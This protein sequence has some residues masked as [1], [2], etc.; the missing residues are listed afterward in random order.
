[1]C[2]TALIIAAAAVAASAAS[3]G[4]SIQSSNAQAANAQYE[5]KVEQQRI[6][7]Q[8]QAASLQ[9]SQQQQ[10]RGREFQRARSSALAS[11]GASG[12]QEN[13]SYSQGIAPSEDKA[14]G[15]D[16]RSIRLNLTGAQSNLADQA[17]VS[18]FGARI[19]KSNAGSAKVGAFA[20][21]ASTALGA[22]DFYGRNKP[23]A[24]PK[25]L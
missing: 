9:A 23:P 7:E 13:L 10:V 18:D 24:K 25:A 20:D 16:L 3:A 14:F 1:M 22:Y 12:L 15:D 4:A 2:A 19:A 11:I 5:S 6:G 17:R 21:F 8:E